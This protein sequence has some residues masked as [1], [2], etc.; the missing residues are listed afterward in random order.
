MPSPAA[1]AAAQQ[2]S[3][4]QASALPVV[5]PDGTA[6]VQQAGTVEAQHASRHAALPDAQLQSVPTKASLSQRGGCEASVQSSVHMNGQAPPSLANGTA[7]SVATAQGSGVPREPH[8]APLAATSRD[9][10]LQAAALEGTSA[11]SQAAVNAGL[12][13][14]T[15]RSGTER[16]Q[17]LLEVQHGCMLRQWAFLH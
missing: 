16:D 6:Q 13:L 14:P 8:V 1:T 9:Q 17:V 5:V 10:Q 7:A 11:S 12:S 3:E 15:P 2:A 4:Q